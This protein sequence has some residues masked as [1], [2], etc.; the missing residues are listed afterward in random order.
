MFN[1][2]SNFSEKYLYEDF[3]DIVVEQASG[4]IY[5]IE[6]DRYNSFNDTVYIGEQDLLEILNDRQQRV[7]V[8]AENSFYYANFTITG[9]GL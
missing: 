3:A 6:K 9:S 1:R 5:H 8:T 2:L 4:G 7:V